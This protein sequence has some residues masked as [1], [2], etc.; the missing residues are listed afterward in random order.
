MKTLLL[1]A[2]ILS[3]WHFIYEFAI[4]PSIRIHLR[5]RLF[6]LRDQLRRAKIDGIRS[7]DE[8]AFWFVHNGINNFLNRLPNLTLAR[9]VELEVK[10]K[11]HADL[12]QVLEDHMRALNSSRDSR[13]VE[14]FNQTNVVIENAMITNMGAWFIYIVPIAVLVAAMGRLSKIAGDL[15]MAPTK[16][17]ER[18]IPANTAHAK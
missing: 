16:D 1:L 4:A 18:L 9:A 8:A 7:E 3:I 12:R 6:V 5:N 13:I 17:V 10:Y 14:V 11:Q 2:L 15:I